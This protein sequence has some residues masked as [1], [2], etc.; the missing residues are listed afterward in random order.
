MSILFRPM[1][2][3]QT[4]M[5]RRMIALVFFFGLILGLAV[6]VR[7]DE[8]LL[9]PNST[10][11][12]PGGLIRGQITAESPSEIKIKPT[13]GAE[14]T[15]PVGQIATITYDGAGQTYAQAEIKENGNQ[16]S[17]AAELFKKAATENAAKKFIAGSAKFRRANIFTD[18]ALASPTKAKEAITELEAY[19]QS[20]PDGRFL[21]ASLESLIRLHLLSGDAVK[22]QLAL[23]QFKDK[24]PGS[25]D[26][27]TIL[28]AKILTK[29]GKLDE[30]I[31]A[32]D[33]AIGAAKGSAKAR[34]AKLAKAETLVVQKKFDDALATVQEVIK[35]SPPEAVDVQAVAHNTLGDCFRAAGRPKDAL[36]AYLQTDIL[37]DKDKEQH[38]RAL[39]MLEQLFRELKVDVRADEIHDRLKQLYPQSPYLTGGTTKAK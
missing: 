5:S 27:V 21:G 8:V 18:I 13:V 6:T 10:F 15:V 11:K 14:Q 32:L 37:F 29:T 24:V 20:Y 4:A 31:A 3:A 2:E 9:I 38:P 1:P 35:E 33:K 7:A 16:L 30:A 23:G 36:I 17:E 34:E 26:R 22:A 12:A 39:A 25:A 19:V 28:E